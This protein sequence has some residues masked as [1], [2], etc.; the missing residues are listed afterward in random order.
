MMLQNFVLKMD[1]TDE[2]QINENSETAGPS[3]PNAQL[4]ITG[5]YVLFIFNT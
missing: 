2:A 1:K 3:N 5:T 4:L